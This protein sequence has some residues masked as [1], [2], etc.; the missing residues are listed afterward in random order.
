MVLP[1]LLRIEFKPVRWWDWTGPDRTGP[2]R[3]GPWLVLLC[4]VMT[5][6][7]HIQFLVSRYHTYSCTAVYSPITGT[8]NVLFELNLGTKKC[9]FCVCPSCVHCL[10]LLLEVYCICV[11]TRTH[12]HA[13]THT[14]THTHTHVYK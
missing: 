13:H 2:D 14:H 7:Q 3:T 12:A 4:D 8:L 11:H 6:I 5:S 9:Y 1:F 10:L